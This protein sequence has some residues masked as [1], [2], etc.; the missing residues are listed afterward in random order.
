MT[1][2]G[3]RPNRGL[4]ILRGV[5]GRC[6]RCGQGRLFRRYLKTVETCPVCGEA[7]GRL[8][9]DDAPP[10]LTI[11]LLG[12]VLVP[13]IMLSLHFDLPESFELVFWLPVSVILAML[14]LPRCKGAVIGFLWSL[15]ER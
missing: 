11:F 14:L 4:A 1:E 6:P 8:P 7:L 5:A 10:W 3:S 15:G 13:G 2:S 12:F 9:A